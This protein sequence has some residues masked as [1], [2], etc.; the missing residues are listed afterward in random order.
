MA[1]KLEKEFILKRSDFDCNGQILPSSV[2]DLFQEAASS[3]AEA[4][5]CGFD[6]MNSKG[7]LWVIARTRYEVQKSPLPCSTV[8]V[9]TWPLAPSIT[10]RR[11]YLIADQNGEILIR[12]S[13]DWLVINKDERS[14]AKAAGVYPENEEPSEALA[15]EGRSK[16]LRPYKGEADSHKV[17]PE[18]SDIDA[19]G[20]VNNTK[21]ADY[22]L[23][24][25]NLGGRRIKYFQIDYH[26]EVLIN[27]LLTIKTAIENTT[28]YAVGLNDSEET[29][30]LCEM[31][32]E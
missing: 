14:I 23:N 8:R 12:G 9:C 15:I 24:A 32:L 13:S 6:D 2:L 5:G 7:L 19:N 30:F 4:L 29:M 3:H 31:E 17:T 22:V 25:V 20:H 10:Y 1:M 28:A 26:K 27:N 16:R 11:E 18:V 21:Y